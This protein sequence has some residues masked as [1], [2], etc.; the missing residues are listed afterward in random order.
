MFLSLWRRKWQP[1]PVFWPGEAH[2]RRGPVGCGLWGCKESNTTKQLTHTHTHTHTQ[3]L[4]AMSLIVLDL[5]LWVFS[6]PFHFCS[7]LLCFDKYLQCF[8]WIPVSF[9]CVQLLY[10]FGLWLARGFNIAAYIYTHT[11]K[12]ILSSWSLNFK[13]NSN[14]YSFLMIAGFAIIF[15]CG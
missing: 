10:I 5:F 13:C 3:V 11:H 9:L 7:L 8:V 4:I 2:G 12:I 6:L 15:V 14:V 1:T